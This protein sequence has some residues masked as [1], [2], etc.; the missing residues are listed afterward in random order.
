MHEWDLFKNPLNYSNCERYCKC[1]FCPFPSTI[2]SQAV[3][4]CKQTSIVVTDVCLKTNLVSKPQGDTYWQTL[5]EFFFTSTLLRNMKCTEA[6]HMMCGL[7]WCYL[8]GSLGMCEHWP[9]RACPAMEKLCR[10][11]WLK[12]GN[13]QNLPKGST[14]T[15]WVTVL[16]FSLG[17]TIKCPSSFWKCVLILKHLHLFKWTSKFLILKILC[18]TWL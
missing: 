6:L 12:P 17:H 3:L 13:L 15:R 14:A 8:G 4:H 11:S 10:C 5:G 2:H 18:A 9:F 7:V 1:Y 16:H